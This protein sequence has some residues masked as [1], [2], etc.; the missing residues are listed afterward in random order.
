MQKSEERNGDFGSKVICQPRPVWERRMENQ[1]A[2]M[3]TRVLCSCGFW[4]G[5]VRNR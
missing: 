3:M 1:M 2:G 5:L 4:G